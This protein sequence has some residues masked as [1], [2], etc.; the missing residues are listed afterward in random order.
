MPTVSSVFPSPVRVACAGW[1]ARSHIWYFTF[2]LPF[3]V[4]HLCAAGV[5]CLC[6]LPNL[7]FYAAACVERG[8]LFHIP[9]SVFCS[10]WGTGCFIAF[11]LVL[12][13][14]AWRDGFRWREHWASMFGGDARRCCTRAACGMATIYAWCMRKCCLAAWA[15]LRADHTH[16]HYYRTLT[17]AFRLIL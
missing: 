5:H 14:D 2:A 13:R 9:L 11:C 3:F 15:H 1:R 6:L 8:H 16:S 4:P 10:V 7:L 12:Y 17:T